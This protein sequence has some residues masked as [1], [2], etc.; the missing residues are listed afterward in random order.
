MMDRR[1]LLIAV[2]GLSATGRFAGAVQAQPSV[3]DDGLYTQ[4]WFLES[5][6]HLAEDLDAAAIS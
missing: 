5:F 2:A 3:T 1:N 4:P 6:L